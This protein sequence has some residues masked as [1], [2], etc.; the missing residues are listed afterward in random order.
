MAIVRTV[1]WLAIWLGGSYLLTT[2]VLPWLFVRVLGLFGLRPRTTPITKKRIARFKS[3]KRGYWSF[4]AIT[5]LFVASLFLE[6]FVNSKPLYIRYGENSAFPALTEWI[7]RATPFVDV[8]SFEARNDFG[9]VGKSEVDYH[10]F[11]ADESDPAAMRARVEGEVSAASAAL[12]EFEIGEKPAPDA[13]QTA[14][15]RW[16]RK[17]K[18]LARAVTDAESRLETV[19][20]FE[21]GDAW[22]LRTLYPWS[23]DD[24]RNDIEDRPPTKPTM[25]EGLPL[26]SDVSGRDVLALMAYGFRI[27]LGFALFVAALGYAV[28]VLVGGIQGYFGGWIDILSQRFV[29]IWGSIPFLFVMMILAATLTPTFWLMAGMLIVL[30]SWIGI[31]YYVRGEFL[32]EKS[33]DY[34]QAA[35]GS[36]VSDWKIITK[37]ILPN[38]IVPVV[39][40]APFGIVAY[41]SSLVSPRLPRLRSPDGNAELGCRCCARAWRTCKHRSAPRDHD[42]GDRSRCHPVRVS[43]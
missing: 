12:A 10:Q 13:R 42:S 29:E 19:D 43:S 39:T 35:I 9:Q 3:I 4:L 36:G 20:V 6:L 11:A 14:K 7:D 27:S 40:F 15:D 21:R 38:S 33:K 22:V 31:T 30:R 5:T 17:R 18:R 26:G 8:G 16:E 1:V 2:L 25:S 24:I 32:R 34:V 23:P 37:H 28:G 41:I